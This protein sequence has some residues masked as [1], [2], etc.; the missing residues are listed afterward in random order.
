MTPLFR[1]ALGPEPAEELP[2]RFRT[3]GRDGASALTT[4]A[5]IRKR[6]GSG[7]L[8]ERKRGPCR[9]DSIFFL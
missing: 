6:R 3:T 9:T 1:Q 7:A 8:Q 2:R 5:P 4:C